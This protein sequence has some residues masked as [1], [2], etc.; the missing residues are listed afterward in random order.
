[1]YKSIVSPTPY[2]GQY[3]PWQAFVHLPQGAAD[4][5]HMCYWEAS[6]PR[7]RGLRAMTKVI[8]L[9]VTAKRPSRGKGACPPEAVPEGAATTALRLLLIQGASS[10]LG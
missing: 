9:I 1:M 3:R 8:T 5:A 10:P 6:P 2:Q 7:P 4:S